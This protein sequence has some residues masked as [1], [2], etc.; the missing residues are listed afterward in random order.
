MG[1]FNGDGI[2]DVLWRNTGS[3]DVA[4]WLMNG[5]TVTQAPHVASGI[6]LTWQI[7]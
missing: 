3:G 7:Q 1:D 6:S 4:E 5:G 2:A